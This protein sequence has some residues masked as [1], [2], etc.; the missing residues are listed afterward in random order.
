[1]QWSSP[2][3]E[4]QNWQLH[5]GPKQKKIQ[6]KQSCS[7]SLSHELRSERTERASEWVSIAE[8]MSEVSSVEQANEWAVWANERTD[9]WK[10]QYFHLGFWLIGPTVGWSLSLAVVP[11]PSSGAVERGMMPE[12]PRPPGG[13]GAG[14]CKTK[15]QEKNNKGTD[16]QLQAKNKRRSE[17]WSKTTKNRDVST[18]PY[19]HLFACPLILHCSLIS[20]L[21]PACLARALR[22][23]YLFGHSLSSSRERGFCPWYW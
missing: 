9:E 21:C 8:C 11:S 22:C 2:L 4:K 10:A 1:M 23:S 12:N 15:K 14:W 18:G 6:I 19:T 5:Y 20:L 17:I 3:N 13:Y 16:I 7:H